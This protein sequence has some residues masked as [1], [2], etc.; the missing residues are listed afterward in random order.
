MKPRPR[1]WLLGAP[2]ISTLK[3]LKQ[4]RKQQISLRVRSHEETDRK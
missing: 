1:E 3:R 4:R 2:S